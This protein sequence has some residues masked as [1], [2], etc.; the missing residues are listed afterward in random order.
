[1]QKMQIKKALMGLKWQ[2]D[3][4]ASHSC[5]DLSVRRCEMKMQSGGFLSTDQSVI[6]YRLK[7]IDRPGTHE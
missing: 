2:N 7:T 3:P 1:M 5:H 6:W 4:H